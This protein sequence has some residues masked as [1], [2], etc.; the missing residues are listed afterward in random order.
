[1]R[2][3]AADRGDGVAERHAFESEND[4]DT[5]GSWPV[6]F[7]DCGPTVSFIDTTELSGTSAPR[8]S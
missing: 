3:D 8:W 2:G 7:T 1:L 6:W 4:T 5:D